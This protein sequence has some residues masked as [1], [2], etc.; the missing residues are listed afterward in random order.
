[1]RRVDDLRIIHGIVRRIHDL[2]SRRRQLIAHKAFGIAKRRF[3]ERFVV[4]AKN[5]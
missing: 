4:K 5:R 2:R 1:M 3:G